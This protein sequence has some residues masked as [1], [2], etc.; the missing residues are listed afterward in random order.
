M[1][2]QNLFFAARVLSKILNWRYHQ[3]KWPSTSLPVS[4]L[5]STIIRRVNEASGLYQMFA[6]LGDVILVD[7]LVSFGNI[8]FTRSLENKQRKKCVINYI[9]PKSY[10]CTWY[11]EYVCPICKACLH[12]FF[13]V[14]DYFYTETVCLNTLRNSPS[15]SSGSS[16][17]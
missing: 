17:K 1:L 10:K 7:K 14:C 2:Y 9:L 13:F 11:A 6:Y 3:E 16:T 4:N 8:I 15:S 5:T 12:G